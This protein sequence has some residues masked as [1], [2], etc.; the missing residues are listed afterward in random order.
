VLGIFSFTL[1]AHAGQT[2]ISFKDDTLGM[3]LADF[4]SKYDHRVGTDPRRAPS[5][6]F[7]KI[8]FSTF[9]A[10]GS[11]VSYRVQKRIVARKN[12]RYESAEGKVPTLPET[13]AGVPAEETYE[14]FAQSLSDWDVLAK[15]QQEISALV[16]IR[17]HGSARRPQAQAPWLESSPE[18]LAAAARVTLGSISV[19]FDDSTSA[20][21]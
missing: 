6:E 20:S 9:P 16:D 1:S 19:N 3:S 17:G 4:C 18:V 2:G 5:L 12:F 11:T 13:I 8:D 10:S 15:R 21:L 7:E 14:F